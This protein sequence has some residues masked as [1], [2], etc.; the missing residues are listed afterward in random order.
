M[1]LCHFYS[2]LVLFLFSQ[3]MMGSR[4]F[5]PRKTPRKDDGT[6]T[7]VTPHV[8]KPV[9]VGSPGSKLATPV[10][11]KTKLAPVT[12]PKKV[13]AVSPAAQE[14]SLPDWVRPISVG[15][16][17]L[18][19]AAD[20]EW[21]ADMKRKFAAATSELENGRVAAAYR[22][23]VDYFSSL[24][25]HPTFRP[26]LITHGLVDTISALIHPEGGFCSNLKDSERISGCEFAIGELQYFISCI[27]AE[28]R[29]Q[30][31]SQKTPAERYLSGKSPIG[32]FQFWFADGAFS[33]G[34]KE[35]SKRWKNDPEFKKGIAETLFR[36]ATALPAEDKGA[37]HL[38]Y[39]LYA[40]AASMGEVDLPRP[41]IP[42]DLAPKKMPG[43]LKVVTSWSSE[44]L[45][46]TEPPSSLGAPSAPP[47][48]SPSTG[49]SLTPPA[50]QPL[51][52]AA[53]PSLSLTPPPLPPLPLVP[54]SSPPLSFTPT[55]LSPLALPPA[56][57]FSPTRSL[58][59]PPLPP[60]PSSPPVSSS[61]YLPSISRS[62]PQSPPLPGVGSTQATSP[63]RHAATPTHLRSIP[64]SNSL[65]SPGAFPML[66]LLSGVSSAFVAK[67]ETAL[68]AGSEGSAGSA[69]TSPSLDS[70]SASSSFP[71]L[72]TSPSVGQGLSASSVSSDVS[73]GPMAAAP[74]V[75]V[76]MSDK[77]GLDVLTTEYV[78]I[79]AGG[80]DWSDDLNAVTRLLWPRLP[81]RIKKALI[82]AGWEQKQLDF[83][84]GQPMV[85][86]TFG[87]AIRSES[88]RQNLR[89]FLENHVSRFAFDV[90]TPGWKPEKK[91]EQKQPLPPVK[92]PPLPRG[93]F[94]PI[95]R[96]A[97]LPVVR[98]L[99]ARFL[100]VGSPET[101][102]SWKSAA[103][104]PASP[105]A[106]WIAGTKHAE[107]KIPK[108]FAPLALP[109]L[110][111]PAAFTALLQGL[112]AIESQTPSQIWD[113]A[114]DV[115]R[116]NWHLLNS[117]VQGH[118]R[119]V[120]WQE[121]QFV[122]SRR[123]DPTL[124]SLKTALGPHA[125]SG[126]DRMWCALIP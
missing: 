10:K 59:P 112:S 16:P 55:R 85:E 121:T 88:G 2:I 99:A 60:A 74:A 82:L 22:E 106:P 54:S 63:T 98:P 21:H 64:S 6:P 104:L 67:S 61:P 101:P 92:A 72:K 20:I 44:S 124:S 29:E 119:E 89:E 87:N 113:Q 34:Y 49:L 13:K 4:F 71:E 108:T 117:V 31:A 73:R 33:N 75:V 123:A 81:R 26:L 41:L 50:L 69:K 110:A 66:A 40:F 14:I 94:S 84:P 83:S 79:W 46:A 126:S 17:P 25:K 90:K 102:V 115:I 125:I 118:L 11:E 43:S 15:M 52:L 103:V 114:S 80:G 38:G 28:L 120:G 19:V 32:L 47:S 77:E 8:A 107:E 35:H 3:T 95:E 39:Y 116:K 53:S 18:D 111:P 27:R 76:P 1:K 42:R 56:P 48:P 23:W 24:L 96:E 7:A 93:L 91:S 36:V 45:A 78:R 57:S 97:L 5:T 109:A 65:A 12:P 9:P 51:A 62:L 70:L 100:P 105:A 86:G 37:N 68:P 30:E 58:M 122:E